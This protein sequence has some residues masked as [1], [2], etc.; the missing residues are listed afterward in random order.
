MDDYRIIRN[1]IISWFDLI[2]DEV[3]K[4]YWIEVSREQVWDVLGSM[5][6]LNGT[7][8][9]YKIFLEL[10]TDSDGLDALMVGLRM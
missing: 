10:G 9:G 5:G 8:G 4:I 6:E 2:I 1:V 3:Q 7:C